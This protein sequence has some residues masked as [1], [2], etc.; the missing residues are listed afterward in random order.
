MRSCI[1]KRMRWSAGPT[2]I[3][4]RSKKT[5]QRQVR[6][7]I[8]GTH[9]AVFFLSHCLSY[10]LFSFCFLTAFSFSLLSFFF[11]CFL[12]FS[13][14]HATLKATG[15]VGPSVGRSVGPSHFA[16]F[17]KVAYRVACARLMAIGLVS[18]CRNHSHCARLTNPP[19]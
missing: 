4:Q 14:V 18:I 5:A 1:S 3:E 19:D 13:R 12:I 16:F 10:I 2:R 8:T 7:P 11:L 15:S 6:E 9:V 17:R